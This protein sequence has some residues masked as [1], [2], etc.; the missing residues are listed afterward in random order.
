M[1]SNVS[2]VD[3]AALSAGVY[4]GNSQFIPPGYTQ[5]ITVTVHLTL[6]DAWLSSI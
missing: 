5:Q 6:I 3:L 1:P 4:Q 2:V